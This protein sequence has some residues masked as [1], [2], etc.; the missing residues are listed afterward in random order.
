MCRVRYKQSCSSRAVICV[1]H[2]CNARPSA[3]SH[4]A[5]VD[6]AE[7]R[8]AVFARVYARARMQ[9]LPALTRA[10]SARCERGQLCSAR[11]ATLLDDLEQVVFGS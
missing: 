6:R 1:V 7:S 5:H 9:K 4:I 2:H 10:D 8:H 11:S 3:R